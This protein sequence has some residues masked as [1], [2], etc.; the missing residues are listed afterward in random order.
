MNLEIPAPTT[1]TTTESSKKYKN[2]KYF[3]KKDMVNDFGVEELKENGELKLFRKI[4]LHAVGFV[5]F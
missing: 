2:K 3:H 5:K 4:F 1:T